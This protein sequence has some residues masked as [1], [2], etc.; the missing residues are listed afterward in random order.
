[1]LKET[2]SNFIR[3]GRP[4]YAQSIS[5]DR[6]PDT[7]TS[8]NVLNILAQFPDKGLKRSDIVETDSAGRPIIPARS[9][10]S[11]TTSIR[12]APGRPPDSNHPLRL[13][14]AGARDFL[15]PLSRA[16]EQSPDPATRG[17]RSPAPEHAGS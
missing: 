14:E 4:G 15:M 7:E 6:N 10:W 1:L 8:F 16:M 17:E 5:F 13:I 3:R 2:L 11:Q 12:N 9:V